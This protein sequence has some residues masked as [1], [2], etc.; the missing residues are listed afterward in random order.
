MARKLNVPYL[1]ALR[2][3]SAFSQEDVAFLLGAFTGTRVSRHETGACVPP[4]EVALAYEVIF[5]VTTAAIYEDEVLRI[6]ARVRKRAR[7]LHES[8]AHRLRD[9]LREE[10]R[11]ALARL[12]TRCSP[13][14]HEKKTTTTTRNR[15]NRK[16]IRLRAP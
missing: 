13:N 1:R 16:G 9:P 7:T 15:P 8:L 6:A 2:R 5:D 3:R 10:K 11:A 14:Q 4:L 12:I